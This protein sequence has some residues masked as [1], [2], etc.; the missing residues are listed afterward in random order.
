MTTEELRQ[1]LIDYYGA[2]AC[3]V[4]AMWG[5]VAEAE[6]ADRGELLRMARDAGISVDDDD[7]FDEDSEND[8][9]DW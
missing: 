2:G 8:D 7:D 3:V 9:I 1:E 4:P 5:A 6:S